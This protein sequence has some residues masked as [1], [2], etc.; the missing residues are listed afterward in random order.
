M[1]D[2]ARGGREGVLGFLIEGSNRSILKL[3]GEWDALG[4]GRFELPGRMAMQGK[5]VAGAGTTT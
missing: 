1:R 2:L 4:G 5:Y 3:T